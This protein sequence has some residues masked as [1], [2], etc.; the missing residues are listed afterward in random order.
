[1]DDSA[2]S[3]AVSYTLPR[4]NELPDIGLY[5]D[6]VIVLADRFLTPIFGGEPVLTASMVNNYVKQKLLAPPCKKRYSREHVARLL[7]I[8]VLKQVLSIPEISHL[9]TVMFTGVDFPEAYDEWCCMQE[10]AF[11]ELSRAHCS[12]AKLA[13]ISVAGKSLFQNL[14]ES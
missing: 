3:A 13:A 1:M 6:Q 7:V 8:C 12:P 4:Y 14:S 5:M 11:Q 2:K 9:M 10:H